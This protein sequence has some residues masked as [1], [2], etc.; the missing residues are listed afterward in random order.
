MKKYIHGAFE[1]ETGVKDLIGYETIHEAALNRIIKWADKFFVAINTGTT[2][3]DEYLIEYEIVANTMQM[4]MGLLSELKYMLK[5]EWKKPVSLW[6][7][8]GNILR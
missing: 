8:R 1:L 4:C 7:E 5:P 6:Q 2:A 3:N